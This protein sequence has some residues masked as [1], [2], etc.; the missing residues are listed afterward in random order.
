MTAC[1][2]FETPAA[3]ARCG[4]CADRAKARAWA[5]G[6]EERTAEARR[7]RIARNR[8]GREARIEAEEARERALAEFERNVTLA[9]EEIEQTVTDV[10]PDFPETNEDDIYHEIAQSIATMLTPKEGAEVRRRLGF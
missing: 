7:R 6:A 2:H 9:L 10:R 1:I 4:P 5:A 3:A 8:K